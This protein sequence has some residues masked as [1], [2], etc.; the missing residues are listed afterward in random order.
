[1][2][3]RRLTLRLLKSMVKRKYPYINNVV[4]LLHDTLCRTSQFV[5]QLRLITWNS[6]SNREIKI[7][8]LSLN[9]KIRRYYIKRLYICAPCNKILVG[10]TEQQQ[11]LTSD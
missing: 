11:R 1:M 5:A 7:R 9:P 10:R 2:Q 6:T 3:N 8:T 4:F